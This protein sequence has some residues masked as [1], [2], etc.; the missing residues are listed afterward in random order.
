VLFGLGWMAG[1]FA[2]V[3]RVLDAGPLVTVAEA[4]RWMLPTDG[5]WRGAIHALQ[6]P[7]TLL[8][9]G[10]V[11]DAANANPFFAPAPPPVGFLVW[12]VV[13]TTLVLGLA[14]LSLERRDL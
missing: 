4:S 8:F 3:G 6:P 10:D 13:W 9:G 1:V 12:A 2:N 14:S 11:A 5:L 7:I